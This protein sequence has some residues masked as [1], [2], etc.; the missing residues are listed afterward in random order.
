VLFEK[1][2]HDYPLIE[3]HSRET[4]D[5]SLLKLSPE[6]LTEKSKATFSKV[7]LGNNIVGCAF[8]TLHVKT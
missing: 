5:D 4:I 6:E 7:E 8:K 3:S 2:R 1:Y